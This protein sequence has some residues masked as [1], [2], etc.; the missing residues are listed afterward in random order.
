MSDNEI[1][2]LLKDKPSDGL[3]EVIQKYNRVIHAIV[4]RILPHHPADVEECVEDTFVNIWKNIS[5]IDPDTPFFKAYILNMARNITISRYRQLKRKDEVSLE[6]IPEPME[7]NIVETIIQ[8]ENNNEI[9]KLILEMEEPDRGIFFRRYFLFESYKQIAQ[10]LKLS[11]VQVKNKLY[12]KKS[13]LRKN[14]SLYLQGTADSSALLDKILDN[15]VLSNGAGDSISASETSWDDDN[16]WAIRFDG[17]DSVDLLKGYVWRYGAGEAF[18]TA[19]EGSWDFSFKVNREDVKVKLTPNCSAVWEDHSVTITN[20]EISPYSLF[21]QYSVDE[22]T[23]LQM[24]P[25]FEWGTVQ[26]SAWIESEH[27]ITL[28]MKDGSVIQILGGNLAPK[29]GNL[30]MAPSGTVVT[31]YEIMW[32]VPAL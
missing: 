5:R 8:A 14:G 11:E 29:G 1:I 22:D 15:A 10:A 21:L 25:P 30:A 7:N 32:M 13:C 26:T 2:Q 16:S 31:E 28:N 12:R 18:H 24:F 6:S 27:P 19:Y 4:R 9:Q 20:L 17:F 23:S 3:Y